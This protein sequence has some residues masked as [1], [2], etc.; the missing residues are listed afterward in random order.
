M[1]SP[2]S[3]WPLCF[4]LSS[5]R[6]ATLE[7]WASVRGDGLQMGLEDTGDQLPL[8]NGLEESISSLCHWVGLRAQEQE[9]GMEGLSRSWDKLGLVRGLVHKSVFHQNYWTA[10]R[11]YF[12]NPVISWNTHCLTLRGLGLECSACS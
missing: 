10:H 3:A 5:D 11:K 12:V 2:I 9:K 4:A 6:Q 7:G 8:H 1:N